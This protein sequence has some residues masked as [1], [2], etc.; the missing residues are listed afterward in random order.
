MSDN[1]GKSSEQA[2]ALPGSPRRANPRYTIKRPIRLIYAQRKSYI[3]LCTENIS[4]RGTFV[5][6]DAPPP[7]N[8]RVEMLLSLHEET[9]LKIDSLVKSLCRLK[10][11]PRVS[12]AS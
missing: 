3:K 4:S 6:M 7:V 12:A 9:A 8:T 2:D 1:H 11:A 5:R 10:A